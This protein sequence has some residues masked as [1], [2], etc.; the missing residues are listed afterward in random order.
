[1]TPVYSRK[2][3]NGRAVWEDARMPAEA[4]D[5]RDVSKKRQVLVWQERQKEKPW[6]DTQNQDVMK[7]L[8]WASIEKTI[9]T[10]CNLGING[11]I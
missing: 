7:C 10:N 5:W 2:R 1:M 6:E 9:I 8:S 4:R 3:K 11:F